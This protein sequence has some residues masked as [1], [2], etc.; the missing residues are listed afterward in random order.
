M[1]ARERQRRRR[2]HSSD[3]A[4]L[5]LIGVA[6]LFGTLIVAVGVV[7][8]YVVSVANN[9]PPLSQLKPIS[10]GANSTVY[11]ANGT[12]LGTILSDKLRTP[13]PS[14]QIP[15]IL[16]EA[17]VAIEDQ[18][19]YQHHGVDFEGIIRAAMTD[20]APARPSRAAR[21]SRCS[22]SE[23]PTAAS[24]SARSNARSRRRSSP[25]G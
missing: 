13:I 1:T 4:R 10:D 21:R 2:R 19:F 15:S 7:L 3:P 25:S 8:G 23:T 5:I 24:T 11:A 22:W 20:L 16:K 12:S 18:R 14:S 9:V 6:A 17:T